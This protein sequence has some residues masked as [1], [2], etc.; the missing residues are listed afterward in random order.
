MS[1]LAIQ[2]LLEAEAE[3]A[4]D[5]QAEF[6]HYVR[7]TLRLEIRLSRAMAEIEAIAARSN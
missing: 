4:A 1:E 7:E 5:Y 6:D 2:E 3:A